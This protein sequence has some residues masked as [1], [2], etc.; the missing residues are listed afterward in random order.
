MY[1][2]VLNNFKLADEFIKKEEISKAAH[3]LDEMEKEIR[4]FE[5]DID[6]TDWVEVVLD[7]IQIKRDIINS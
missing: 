7:S 6:Y 4:K 5:N 2:E 1:K 3:L